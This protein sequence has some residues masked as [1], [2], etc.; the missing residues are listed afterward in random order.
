[1]AEKTR[2]ELAPIR[3]A[4]RDT[5][6]AF[7]AQCATDTPSKPRPDKNVD[8]T[9]GIMGNKVVQFDGKT[10]KIYGKKYKL[11]PGLETMIT[12]GH[13]QPG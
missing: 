7:A 12:Q 2:E 9:F 1:M 5:N 10:F 4:L 6:G 3:K 13:P 11:T 8:T